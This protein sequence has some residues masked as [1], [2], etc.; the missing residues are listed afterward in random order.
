MS[1]NVWA[2]DDLFDRLEDPGVDHCEHCARELTLDE[3]A[4]GWPVFALDGLLI[5][6]ECYG[7]E[8]YCARCGAL[9]DARADVTACEACRAAQA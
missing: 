7:D 1:Y 2:D 9:L 4:A 5:C 8:A 3:R 6:P